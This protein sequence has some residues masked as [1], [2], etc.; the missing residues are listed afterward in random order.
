MW[1]LSQYI[2]GHES[3]GRPDYE[4]RTKKTDS[5]INNNPGLEWRLES[6][7]YYIFYKKQYGIMFNDKHHTRCINDCTNE[8]M[9]LGIF[10]IDSR[11]T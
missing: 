8:N 7:R 1:H 11:G 4:N 6:H 3:K 5:F 2:N 9:L 10:I